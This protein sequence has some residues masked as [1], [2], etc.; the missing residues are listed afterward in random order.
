MNLPNFLTIM[1]IVVGAIVPFMMVHPEWI[2][3]NTLNVRI[4]VAILFAIA[5][6]SDW[7]DG[8]YARK[9][10]LIT[11]TGQILDP[12]AEKVITIG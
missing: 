10:N 3:P 5:A 11:K 1:R 9:Y 7:F 2:H 12:I 6:F 4:W 8:W